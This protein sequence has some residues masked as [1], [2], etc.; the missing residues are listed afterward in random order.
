MSLFARRSLLAAVLLLALVAAG[1]CGKKDASRWAYSV[2]G[3]NVFR[4]A[5]QSRPTTLD[6]ALVEDGDTID[7]L[8][9]VFEGLV[10]WSD[11]NEVVPNIAEKWEVSPDGRTYTFHLRSDVKFHKPYQRV[12]TA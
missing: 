11:K 9:Q 5:M 8:M 10:M 6:P 1:G 3:G 12:V 4:Y 2:Q 7:M